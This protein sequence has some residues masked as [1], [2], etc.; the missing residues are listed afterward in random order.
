MANESASLRSEEKDSLR[1]PGAANTQRTSRALLTS[2]MVT[3]IRQGFD[4]WELHYLLAK[5]GVAEVG[6]EDTKG[7]KD[8]EIHIDANGQLELD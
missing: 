8:A 3:Q 5:V 6:L 4:N 2:Q 1:L 7:V